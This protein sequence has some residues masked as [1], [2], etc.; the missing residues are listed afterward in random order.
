MISKNL[1]KWEADYFFGF[2]SWRRLYYQ[3]SDKD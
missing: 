2:A 3:D 1:P